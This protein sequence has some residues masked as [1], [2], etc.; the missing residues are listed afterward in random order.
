MNFPADHGP[1]YRETFAAAFPAEPW[2]TAS[3]VVFLLIV[4][5]FLRHTRCD[6]RRYPMIVLSLPILFTGF[7][8]G[9]VY[10]ATRSHQIWLILDYMPIVILGI[11]GS[12]FFWRQL[13]SFWIAPF[14]VLGGLVLSGRL[15]S[16]LSG[17]R[18]LHISLGYCM[19]AL[20]ILVPAVINSGRNKWRGV[21]LLSIAAVSF[22]A[23]V[24]FRQWDMQSPLSVF[25]MGTHFLW[26]I[27]GGASAFAIMLHIFNSEKTSGT[28]ECRNLQF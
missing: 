4:M 25:P 26:H 6:W 10:H 9:T 18:S 16:M 13:S 19:V 15:H 24:F 1:L 23:A 5:H 21:G 2:N 3:N 28:A 8:S 12:Y 20:N 7:A 27:F 22:A 11:A 14:L 17:P